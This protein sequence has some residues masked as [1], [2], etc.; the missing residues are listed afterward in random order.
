MNQTT[1]V[2]LAG[3]AA[4]ASLTVLTP[5]AEAQNRRATASTAPTAA[6]Q[7]ARVGAAL[8]RNV[9]LELTESR[10]ED[11]VQFIRDFAGLEIDAFWA[12]DT[13]P[14]GLDKDREITITVR[15]VQVIDLLERVLEK[16]ST[17]FEQATWQFNRD[18]SGI[19]IGP[20]SRL[21]ARAYMK[22]YDVNDMLY[23]IPNFDNA[24]QLDLDQVLNQGQRGGGGGGGSIFEDED[25]NEAQGLA[26]EELARQLQ[27]II[28]EN[29]E[30]EQWVDNGGSG[31][32]IRFYN[33]TF[34]VRAPEYIHRQ[35]DPNS[36][37]GR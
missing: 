29:V 33:G 24:P 25:D 21:N 1:F 16:A 22:I 18:G 7:R 8:S 3:V 20:K 26:A 5:V 14:D 17:E 31:A 12:D 9:T 27:D 15:E 6:A 36:L 19:E 32:T 10:L 2:R 30:P 23:Q 34:I 28:L 35:L 13:N 37:P 4:L 11:V